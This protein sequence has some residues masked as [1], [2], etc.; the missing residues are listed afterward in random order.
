MKTLD[1]ALDL[2][3]NND[4]QALQDTG[5]RV[6]P[7]AHE[8]GDNHKVHVMLAAFANEVMNSN[9]PD[10]TVEV[11]FAMFINGLVVGMA[12]ERSENGG[13]LLDD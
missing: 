5:G 4:T 3:V 13:V 12:M 1:E 9:N 11:L 6:V 2:V 8:A 7:M 10:T